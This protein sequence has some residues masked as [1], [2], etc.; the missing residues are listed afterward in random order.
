MNV[1]LE[2]T[3]PVKEDVSLPVTPGAKYS[4]T[5]EAAKEGAF[6]TVEMIALLLFPPVQV[7]FFT[8]MADVWPMVSDSDKHGAVAEPFMRFTHRL[9]RLRALVSEAAMIGVVASLGFDSM[10]ISLKLTP[11]V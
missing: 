4:G 11:K 9:L 10:Y 7:K 1:E 6:L 3:T 8:E 5:W 2:I